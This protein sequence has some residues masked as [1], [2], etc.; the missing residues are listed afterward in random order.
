MATPETTTRES[1]HR[2][3]MEA[4]ITRLERAIVALAAHVGGTGWYPDV[5]DHL[6][7]IEADLRDRDSAAPSEPE[8]A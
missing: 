1:L 8:A 7:A 5:R 6:D 2:G 4:R 3:L